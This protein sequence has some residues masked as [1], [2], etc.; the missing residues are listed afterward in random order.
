MSYLLCTAATPSY[1]AIEA[2]SIENTIVVEQAGFRQGCSTGDQVLL[3][4]TFI[5][6]GFQLNQKKL[7]L[8]FRPDSCLRCGLAPWVYY[9]SSPKLLH[10]GL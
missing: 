6:N 7:E 9:R 10:V 4:T 3:L 2:N 5:E 8:S 1:Q